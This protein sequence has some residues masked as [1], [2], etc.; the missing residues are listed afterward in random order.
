MKTIRIAGWLNFKGVDEVCE[1]LKTN[2]I[3]ARVEGSVTEFQAE[4]FPKDA[5]ELLEKAG[6][7]VLSVQE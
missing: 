6:F 3:A 2:A 1:V 4:D 5:K 7:E